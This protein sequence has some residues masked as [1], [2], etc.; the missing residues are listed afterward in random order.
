LARKAK[1]LEF[2]LDKQNNYN[3]EATKVHFDNVDS[4][5]AE[6]HYGYYLMSIANKSRKN[7][8]PRIYLSLKHKEEYYHEKYKMGNKWYA[9]KVIKSKSDIYFRNGKYI[10]FINSVI[11]EV[12]KT[13]K[14]IK[15][16]KNSLAGLDTLIKYYK[17]EKIDVKSIFDIS[18]M[19]IIA[20]YK[21]MQANK[22]IKK[23]NIIE[24]DDLLSL[25]KLH[26]PKLKIKKEIIS[27]VLSIKT[28]NYDNKA[29]PSTVLYQLEKYIKVE[30]KELKRKYEE[31]HEWKKRYKSESFISKED[32]LKTIFDFVEKNPE[33]RISSFIILLSEKLKYD[34]GTNVDFI[35]IPKYKLKNRISFDQKYLIK[36]K[37]EELKKI[38]QNG[39][40]IDLRSK[41]YALYWFKEIFPE[42][43]YS[44]LIFEKYQSLQCKIFK[45]IR[46]WI[47]QYFN[48]PLL[49]I[50]QYLYPTNNDLYPLYLLLLIKTGVNQESLRNIKVMPSSN[51]SVEI[52]GDNLELFTIINTVKYKSNSN[53]TIVIKNNSFE[54][55]YINLFLSMY[56]S[57]FIHSGSDNLFQYINTQGGTGSIYQNLSSINIT[58]IKKSPQSFYKKYKIYDTND[59]RIEYI[60]HTK[61]RKSHNYQDFLR[62]KTEFERQLKK[63][64]KSGDTTKIYYESQNFE[65]EESKHHKIALA[66]NLVVGIFRGEITREDH[67]S[68]NLFN[69]PMADCKDNKNPAFDNAP[70]LK[71]NE[72]CSDWTKCLTQC[73]KS[74]V[75][76]KI[77]GPVILA[78][79][80]YLEKQKDDFLRVQDWEKEYLIDY[81]SAKD[82]FERFTDQEMEYCKKVSYKYDN[83]VN[84]KFS[85]MTKIKGDKYA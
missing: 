34:Y 73:D 82:T 36:I 39:K 67:K 44:N 43:P 12:F 55:K 15:K 69:G 14:T 30:Y 37:K 9:K 66:Q 33:K 84:I 42:Y 48:I 16:T 76:P 70:N 19:H 3:K 27:E 78:W 25:I 68:V 21:F 22:K 11:N 35:T 23:N 74:C 50:D 81:Q 57:I 71:E 13:K 41:K 2:N 4:T 63:S 1:Q 56:K 79:I 26:L 65:W 6:E 59:K 83:F 28:K 38:A 60:K 80:N 45:N 18:Q 47:S 58:N 61:I 24:L 8:N 64:H 49:E 32:L 62:G 72:Y 46:T 53:I 10:N 5:L 51:N 20:T 17:K 85:R 75:V 77:H 29:L 7:D 40:N 52:K 54:K 31:Y